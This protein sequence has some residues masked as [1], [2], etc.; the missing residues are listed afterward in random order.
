[1]TKSKVVSILLAFLW[2][3]DL[4]YDWQ[5]ATIEKRA[6]W[7]CFLTESGEA[8]VIMAGMMSMLLSSA[9]SLDSRREP[10]ATS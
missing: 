7:R 5:V 1:M 9:D 10:F 4:W 6:E 8:S 2:F 3:Q